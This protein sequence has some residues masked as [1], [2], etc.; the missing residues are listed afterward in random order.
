MRKIFTLILWSVFGLSAITVLAIWVL[1]FASTTDKD[2][3]LDCGIS[4]DNRQEIKQVTHGQKKYYLY[5]AISGGHGHI[6]Y[7]ELYGKI[8]TINSCGFAVTHP[9]T[10]AYAGDREEFPVKIF[11]SHKPHG[12]EMEVEYE[13]T[14]R[15]NKSLKNVEVI[16]KPAANSELKQVIINQKTYY[17]YLQTSGFLKTERHFVL[18]EQRPSFD[19]YGK[20]NI[21]AIG[22]SD[23]FPDF[24]TP[25]RIFVTQNP[26]REMEVEYGNATY[27]QQS[28]KDVAVVFKQASSLLIKQVSANQKN[29]YLYLQTSGFPRP[30]NF[31]TLY[32]KQPSFDAYGHGHPEAVGYS[33]I[34]HAPDI[35]VKIIVTNDP[36]LDVRYEKNGLYHSLFHS[37]LLKAATDIDI[38]IQRDSSPTP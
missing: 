16:F 20:A 30:Q 21:E 26:Y 33:Y 29:Y 22:Y 3:N 10:T 8:P 38:S 11:V 24:G 14:T 23:I 1:A 34:S 35:P 25:V 15:A 18:Y 37:T 28:L 12:I 13:N 17:L 36:E 9:L 6:Q 27:N 32:D 2:D 19:A 31:F 5:L 7:F 4:L